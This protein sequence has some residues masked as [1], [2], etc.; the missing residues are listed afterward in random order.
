M[1]SWF[2]QSSSHWIPSNAAFFM[3]TGAGGERTAVVLPHCE[4]ECGGLDRRLESSN[5]MEGETNRHLSKISGSYRRPFGFVPWLF[6][7]TLSPRFCDPTIDIDVDVD[8]SSDRSS[9]HVVGICPSSSLYFCPVSSW[10]FQYSTTHEFD[11]PLV[12]LSPLLLHLPL[13]LPVDENLITD[14]RH[15]LI[16]FRNLTILHCSKYTGFP[17]PRI[18]FTNISSIPLI[19]TNNT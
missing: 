1:V 4:C 12:L 15:W 8:A 6:V 10:S 11:P 9:L 7:G 18:R 16:S 13:T 19:V 3:L 17:I 2:V 14:F 5:R